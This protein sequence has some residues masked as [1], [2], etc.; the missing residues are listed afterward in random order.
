MFVHVQLRFVV[1]NRNSADTTY[2]GKANAGLPDLCCLCG[3]ETVVT[4][5]GIGLQ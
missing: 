4:G 3:L 5:T 1:T 2:T